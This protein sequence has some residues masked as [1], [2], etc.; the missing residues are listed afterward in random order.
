MAHVSQEM[1]AKLAPEIKR[2]NK[3]YGIKASLGVDNHSTLVLKIREGAVDFFESYNRLGRAAPR[4]QATP[5]RDEDKHID[6]NVY[7]FNTHFDGVAREYL[8]EMINAMKGP[9]FFDHSDIQSDFFH[10]SHYVSIRIGNWQAPY[11][12]SK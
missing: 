7:W 2:I 4:S 10:K 3:K 9:D 12:L 5:W 8:E 11:V 1:K 6:V